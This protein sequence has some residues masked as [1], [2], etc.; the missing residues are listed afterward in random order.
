MGHH[1]RRFAARLR[2][3]LT[4]QRVADETANE[5]QCHLEMLTE[6]YVASGMAPDEARL[7]ATRQLGNVTRVRE[8]VHEMNGLGWVETVAQDVG[9]ACR[10]FARTPS[11]ASVVVLTLAL[12]IGANSALL[13]LAYAALVE[14][15]PYANPDEIYSAEI[16]LS[17]R[18]D[19]IP[20]LPAS[21]QTFLAWRKAATVFAGM[22]ALTPWE[23][24]VT[25]DGEPER[26][27][28]ARVSSN[29]FAVLGVPM[30]H[31]RDFSYDDERPGNER[32]VIISDGLWAQR[33]GGDPAVVGREMM[34]NGESHRIAGVAPASLLVPTRTEMHTLLPFAQRVDVWKPIVAAPGRINNENWDHGVFVRLKDRT[35]IED[36]R[37]QLA[38]ILTELARVQM[39]NVDTEVVIQLLPAREIYAGRVRLRLLLV[40]AA[41]ALLLLVACASIANVFLASVASRANEFATRVAL[42][43]SRA[44]ILSQTVTEAVLLSLAGGVLGALVAKYGTLAVVANGPDELRR[45][46]DSGDLGPLLV[47]AL[48]VSLV[49][50]LA[51]GIVP[52][53]NAWRPDPGAT[54]LDAARTTLGG[55][56]AGRLRQL[57][58][59]V[60][61]ALAT[62]L[63]A[64]AGLLMHSFVR[65][66]DTDRG[67]SIERVLAVD[68]SLFGQRYASGAARISFY[69]VLLD[70]VRA[71]PGV[72][73][74]GAINNLPASAPWDGPSPTIFYSTDANFQQLVLSRPVA[75]IRSV[76]AGYL[77]ASGSPLLAGRFVGAV[78]PSPVCAI[79]ESLATRMWPGVPLSDVVGRQLRHGDIKGPLVEIVGVIGDAQPAGLDR[80]PPPAVYRPYAQWASGPMTLLVRTTDDPSPL[81][82]A[83]RGEVRRMDPNLPIAAMRTMREVIGASVAPRRFQL[84]LTGLFAVVALLL[85]A[86]AVYGVVSHS[87][88]RRTREIGLRMALGALRSQVLRSI[89]AAGMRPVIA[90]LAVGLAAAIAAASV[91]RGLLF[92]IAPAD[93][94]AIGSVAVV[95]LVTSGVA[96]YLPARRA[97]RLDPAIALRAD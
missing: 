17:Q 24:S 7:A 21:L 75:M 65:L 89:V 32:V 78:E 73:A 63:L 1:L 2:F 95:L 94:L 96:C 35:T 14:P 61:M 54:L 30:V 88:A 4:R 8:D 50:G 23:A 62:L 92:G 15:L 83:V 29:F 40:L 55:R 52:A 90:G 31:G 49:T 18:R 38:A 43:A 16:V 80:E 79:S 69:T 93:P 84:V 28:G 47:V 33:Y 44:R 27:G 60:E 59:A 39:P 36:G 22:A 77:A 58:V 71:L 41:S 64:S 67:Y 6:R 82:A 26:L 68:L 70:N 9:H 56:R 13:R 66:M 3:V 11:L 76:T 72:E 46:A 53:W 74:A 25:G 81:A 34:L 45:L 42:G 85:G 97:A 48:G 57:L 19:Q 5:L 86:I 10:L 37:R 91:L 20:S 12:G 87:V 51:C